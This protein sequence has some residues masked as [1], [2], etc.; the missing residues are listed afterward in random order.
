LRHLFLG[1]RHQLGADRTPC[2]HKHPERNRS[3]CE[4]DERDHRRAE[5]DPGPAG[6]DGFLDCALEV[7]DGLSR[8]G[9][10]R[11]AREIVNIEGGHAEDDPRPDGDQHA[12]GERLC[13]DGAR[14][15]MN[16]EVI[17]NPLGAARPFVG[18]TAQYT[19]AEHDDVAVEVRQRRGMTGPLGGRGE[20]RG[21]GRH[22]IRGHRLGTRAAAGGG[23]HQGREHTWND[24][25]APL[26][27]RRS[28]MHER[29]STGV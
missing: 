29:F 3:D 28:S 17:K 11:F 22:L 24:R 19:R 5:Q 20:H 14:H 2:T 10:E 1:Q 13:S 8:H 12:A 16:D 4:D 7:R 6:I 23:P 18:F 21:N 25:D 15:A 9:V 27:H 26:R